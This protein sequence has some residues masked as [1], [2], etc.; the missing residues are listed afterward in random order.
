[1]IWVAWKNGPFRQS[2]A[3]YGFRMS[4][5]D[6]D[7]WFD[8]LWNQVVL[9]LRGMRTRAHVT[10]NINKASFWSGNCRELISYEIGTWMNGEGLAPWRRG[11]PPKFRATKSSAARFVVT[12]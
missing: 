1:M 7:R 10:V 5:D 2:G 6:R 3:G 9:E 8:P 11:A 4:R 12:T